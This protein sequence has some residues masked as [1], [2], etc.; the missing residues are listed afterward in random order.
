MIRMELRRGPLRDER[1]L[2]QGLIGASNVTTNSSKKTIFRT[3]RSAGTSFRPFLSYWDINDRTCYGN[4]HATILMAAVR[5]CQ[6]EVVG[7]LHGADPAR[8]ARCHTA[9]CMTASAGATTA[10]AFCAARRCSSRLEQTSIAKVCG[11]RIYLN[12]D[13]GLTPLQCG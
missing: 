13:D 3:P 12:G 11:K 6:N 9:R 8:T 1:P 4:Q 2:R 7:W 5:N 10:D